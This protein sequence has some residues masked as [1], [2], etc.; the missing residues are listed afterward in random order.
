MP[1]LSHVKKEE[2]RPVRGNGLVR[3]LRGQGEADT[4]G[5]PDAAAGGGGLSWGRGGEQGEEVEGVEGLAGP[6][7]KFKGAMGSHGG[8]QR[9]S[10]RTGAAFPKSPG[11]CVENGRRGEKGGQW[12]GSC[13]V[14]RR[15]LV[16]QCP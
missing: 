12:G 3:W 4:R 1:K 11:C 14:P 9:E 5:E 13:S 8:L 15:V 2:G 6:R 7:A 16:L 10:S